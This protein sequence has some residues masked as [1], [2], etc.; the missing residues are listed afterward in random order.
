MSKKIKKI[1]EFL[2]DDS[3]FDFNIDTREISDEEEKE[4]RDY[5]NKMTEENLKDHPKKAGIERMTID[6]FREIM[7]MAAELDGTQF[8][9]DD[10]EELDM[11]CMKQFGEPFFKKDDNTNE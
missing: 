1:D 9:D 3:R 6:E 4:R 11:E 8:S 10:I 2:D 5:N 7:Y